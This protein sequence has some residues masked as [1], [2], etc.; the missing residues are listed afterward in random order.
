MRL[1]ELGAMTAAVRLLEDWDEGCDTDE[2]TRHLTPPD[3]V[4]VLVVDDEAIVRRA[5]R[6]MLTR[7]GF[8]VTTATDVGPALAAV[9]I[10]P[11][12][13]VLVDLGMPTSGLELIRRLKD[14]Y[15]EAMYVAV[16]S[17][18]T[19]EQLQDQCV[20]C[21]AD[22]YLVKSMT[23]SELQRHL[24][25]AARKQR[26]YV[27]AR[28]E[29]E[30]AERMRTYGTEAASMLAHDLNNNLTAGLMN[31]DYLGMTVQLGDEQREVLDATRLALHRM[32]A[33]V[34]NFVDIARFEDDQLR[35]VLEDAS[36]SDM[37]ER[38]LGAHRRRGGP[39]LAS[40][41]EPHLRGAI[42][43]GRV[44]RLLHNLVGN[45]VRYAKAGVG[46]VVSARPWP[47]ADYTR[48]VE[49]CVHNSGPHVP[50][51]VAAR[52]FTKY[53]RGT[54]GARGVGLYF[55]RLVCEAHHGTIE[56]VADDDGPTFRVRLPGRPS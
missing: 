7:R 54:D 24:I 15:G 13:L 41:I 29:R 27:E 9:R 52:L 22:D 43:R 26:A 14:E 25:V 35:P 47:H 46:V 2:H 50:D 10:C 21:G 39:A 53:T 20:E 34:S 42:D 55:C 48:G 31:L 23:P 40:A 3:G 49:L 8:E 11:P 30:R 32:A 44:E 38:V 5:V 4:R 33:L 36:I 1:A 16:L 28:R 56:L 18:W 19:T 45:A 37:V 17:G 12:D 51:A 6:T